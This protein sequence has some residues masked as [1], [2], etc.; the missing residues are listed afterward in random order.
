MTPFD[1]AYL[2]QVIKETRDHGKAAHHLPDE[3]TH[4]D[5]WC[6]ACNELLYFIHQYEMTLCNGKTALS[7]QEM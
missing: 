5:G 2:K 1:L 6:D 4:W 3:D 7:T